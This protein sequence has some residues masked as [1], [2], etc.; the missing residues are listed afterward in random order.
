MME[1]ISTL[2]TSVSVP[3]IS[4]ITIWTLAAGL[5]YLFMKFFRN[6]DPLIRYHLISAAL[7]ALPTGITGIFIMNAFFSR[8]RLPDGATINYE[9]G[10]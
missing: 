9:C 7:I 1:T 3:L 10:V 2:F 8:C 6:G 5:I 4:A